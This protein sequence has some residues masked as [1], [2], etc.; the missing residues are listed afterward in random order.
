MERS[1]VCQRE[2]FYNEKDSIKADLLF[3][4]SFVFANVFI[5]IPMRRRPALAGRPPEFPPAGGNPPGKP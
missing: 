1:T 3:M 5:R 2:S 4:L